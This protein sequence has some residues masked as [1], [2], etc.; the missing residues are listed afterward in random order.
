MANKKRLGF[1][2]LGMMGGSMVKNLLKSGYVPNV[3]DIDQG[4]MNSF[5]ALGAIPVASSKEVGEKS[6]IVFSSLPDPL[7]V[8]KVY[9]E[10][11]GIIEKS[12]PESIFID[13]STVDPET[14]RTI[15][16]VAAEKKINYLDAPV[17]GGPGEAEA[18]KLI[19]IVGGDRNAFDKCRDIFDIIGSTVHYAGQSGAGNVIKLVNN[20]MAMGNV[21][22]AAEAFVLGVKAGVDGQTLFNIIRTSGGRSFHF[23]KRFPNILLRN[24]EPRFTVD[25]AKKD[26]SLALDMAKNM[27]APIPVTNLVHQLYSVSSAIGDGQKDFAA[28]IRLFESWVG[29]QVQGTKE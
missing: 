22:I 18:G 21:L 1:I 9:L 20:V 28:I 10:P 8:K 13:M 14:S 3:Y 25:L 17:S 19:V 11:D 24:F 23:E 27:I 2:G 29:V 6:N 16:N 4:K 15:C 5:K 26:L 7:I 12:S